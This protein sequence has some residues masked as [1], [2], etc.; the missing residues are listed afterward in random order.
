MSFL[1]SVGCTK[2]DVP[3]KAIGA[4]DFNIT[5]SF[6]L[7]TIVNNSLSIVNDTFLWTTKFGPILYLCSEPFAIILPH[8]IETGGSE[9]VTESTAELIISAMYDCYL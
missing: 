7:H 6:Y 3:C 4:F 8:H 2:L 5:F 1:V 9:Y